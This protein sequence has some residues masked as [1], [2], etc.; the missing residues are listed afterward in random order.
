MEKYLDRCLSSLIVKGE[1][2]DNLEV[3]VI[4]DGSKDRSSEIAH[5]YEIRYP[6]T[7]RVIDKENGNYGSCVNRGLNEAQG[8]YIKVLD[9]DDTFDNKAFS[10]FI[11]VLMDK[12]VDCVISEMKKVNGVGEDVEICSFDLP[13]DLS[14][15]DMSKVIPVSDKMWMHCACFRTEKLK[16]TGYFQ[17]EGISYT[18]QEWIGLPMA[19]SSSFVYFPDILYL[20]LVG[21][22]GQ[23]VDPVVW[24][25]NFDQEI[26]GVKVMMEERATY[27]DILSKD[28]LVYF[29]IRIIQRIKTIFYNYFLLFSGMTNHDRMAQLDQQVFEYNRDLYGELGKSIVMFKSFH[30]LSYWRDRDY[31]VSL[32][33]ILMKK[34]FRLKNSKVGRYF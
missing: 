30:I 22:S 16:S 24:E 29:D 33:I 7:F 9:A 34:L 11:D 17:T 5:A 23:T 10:A 13:D 19:I 1:Q 31:K 20:Y 25:K 4:N 28:G 3:L 26:E 6:Q 2:M 18:D 21:R 8:K 32:V 14:V 12:D 27:N 15:F